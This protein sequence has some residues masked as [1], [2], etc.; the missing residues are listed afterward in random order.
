MKLLTD[1]FQ[2]RRLVSA[3]V[4]KESADYF[5]HKDSEYSNTRKRQEPAFP[6]TPC[7]SIAALWEYLFNHN[8]DMAFMFDTE[9]STEDLIEGL[10]NAAIM[11]KEREEE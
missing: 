11:V 10:V 8:C 3:G 9:Q 1:Y 4:P 7:W 2:S 5:F 6:Y